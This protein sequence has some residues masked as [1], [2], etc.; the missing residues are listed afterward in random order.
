MSITPDPSVGD[1]YQVQSFV[2][3]R[4]GNCCLGEGFVTVSDAECRRIAAFLGMELDAF[5]A[6]YTRRE[7][8]YER[9]LKDAPGSDTPCVFLR[10]DENGLASCLIQG[11]AKPD[12]CRSFPTKWRRSDA[13]DWCASMIAARREIE[14]EEK[15][16]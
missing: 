2:C 3:L 9:W 7:P 11:D 1:D 13:P 16:P 12:Q 10:R 14:R 4:C 5:L 15:T 8:G 6:Q